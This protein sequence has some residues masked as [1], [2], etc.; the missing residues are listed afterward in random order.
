MKKELEISEPH[1]AEGI[2]SLISKVMTDD[3]C[4]PSAAIEHFSQTFTDEEIFRRIQRSDTPV[5]IASKNGCL[6]GALIGS[7][8]EGGVGTI[9]WLI[10]S[11]KFRNL[12]IG[13]ALFKQACKAYRSMGCHK[14]KLTASTPEAVKFYEKLG[15]SIEG[16]HISHWWMLDFWSFGKLLS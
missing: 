5:F 2:W 10:V 14:V 16:K 9:I 13:K 15:M 8:P 11:S 6:A 3:L 12:G 7:S 1:T 4:F